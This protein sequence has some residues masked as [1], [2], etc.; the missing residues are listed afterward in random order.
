M[1]D[2]ETGSTDNGTAIDTK[3]H[4][5]AFINLPNRNEPNPLT[6][7][8]AN[9]ILTDAEPTGSSATTVKVSCNDLGGDSF[10][11][12]DSPAGTYTSG[13]ISDID[14]L[15]PYAQIEPVSG[16]YVTVGLEDFNS[17][18]EIIMWWQ[19]ESDD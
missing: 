12:S 13:D 2:R 8:R 14:G 4:T 5:G 6:V 17:V 19:A 1:C 11:S 3:L 10:K 16:R 9:K 7:V 18:S 15:V